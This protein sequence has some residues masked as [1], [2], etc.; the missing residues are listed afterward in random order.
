M[1]KFLKSLVIFAVILLFLS[2]LADTILSHGLKKA[3]FYTYGEIGVWNDVISGNINSQLLV[4]GSSRA[5]VHIDPAMIEKEIQKSC[6]NLG[7]DGHTFWLQYLRHLEY[8]KNNT[9]PQT[10]IYSVDCF[11]LQK[12]KDLY[13]Y[14]QFLPYMLFDSEF[15]KYTSSYNGFGFFDYFV[16][17]LRYYGEHDAT[18]KAIDL[19]FS[20][21]PPSFRHKGYMGMERVWD[22]GLLNALKQSQSIEFNLDQDSI[23]LLEQFVTECRNNDIELILVYTPEYREGQK[24][25]KNRNDIINIFREIAQKNNIPFLD[26]SDSPLCENTE[27]FYN[28]THLN[29]KGA[30][31]FT[32]QLIHDL[33]KSKLL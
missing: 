30:E 20:D 23:A 9:K 25:I 4:Y 18:Q 24:I 19:I 8:M 14:P 15:Y 28:A 5:W 29:K 16:P 22:A 10:I 12:L 26:Y 21:P 13:N 32:E 1:K 33:K 3:Q 6:Y 2:F 31:L 11:T 7:I 27:Y 17:L